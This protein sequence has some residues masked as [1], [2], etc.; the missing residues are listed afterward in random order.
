LVSIPLIYPSSY[1]SNY[2]PAGRLRRLLKYLYHKI[3]SPYPY[4]KGLKRGRILD[5][6]CAA[7]ISNYPFGED[8]SLRQLKSQGWDVHGVEFDE[9]AAN[10]ARSHGINVSIG[11]LSNVV[12][13]GR[14]F[15]VVRFNHVLEHSVSPSE[16]LAAAAALLSED[17]RV[18]VSGPN[19]ASA[20]FYLFQKY[21]SGL[22]L[23]R[24]F[25]HYTPET[26]RLYC[27]KAGLRV[28]SEYHDGRPFDLVHSIRHFLQSK[29]MNGRNGT[30]QGTDGTRE[31]AI[32][33][34]FP[35]LR[36]LCL[37][38]AAGTLATLFNRKAL[39]DSLTIVAMRK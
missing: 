36:R 9:A 35:R 28:I 8:G 15:D 5:V 6:G 29:E 20:A 10:I 12:P 32:V 31:N 18:I 11:R 17:G 34:I 14:G 4:V 37:Y 16:D 25:Y 39:S 27:E 24:H 30:C 38:L 19:I 22:D 23:P 2:K 13:D 21:W 26:L 7:G 1:Y 33:S 3:T